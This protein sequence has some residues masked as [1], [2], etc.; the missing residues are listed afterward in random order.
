MRVNAIFTHSGP[1]LRQPCTPAALTWFTY[2]KNIMAWNIF[3]RRILFFKNLYFHEIFLKNVNT[4]FFKDFF[5]H[6]FIQLGKTGNKQVNPLDITGLPATKTGFHCEN[7]N[8]GKPCFLY[9]ESVCC[10]KKYV[11]VKDDKSTIWKI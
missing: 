10:R 9:N 1:Y 8:T 6:V 4:T 5:F 7:L 2:F 3:W 11:S